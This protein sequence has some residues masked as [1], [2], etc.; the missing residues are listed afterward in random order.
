MNIST[1]LRGISVA[2]LVLSASTLQAATISLTTTLAGTNQVPPN[3]SRGFGSGTMTYDDV[4]NQLDWNIAFSDLVAGAT[5]AHFH[6]PAAPGTN[7]SVQVPIPLGASSGMTSGLLTGS[8][9]LTNA[10]GTQLLSDLWYVNIHSSVFPGGEIRG[11]AQV[12]PLPAAA[13]LLI[14]GLSGLTLTSVRRRTM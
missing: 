5:A 2:A 9:T 11:Q 14:S 13:W 3:A 6:G 1:V 8:A 12:V 7:A 10:Q 4:T